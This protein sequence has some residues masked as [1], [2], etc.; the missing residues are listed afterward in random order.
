MS[1]ILSELDPASALVGN[2][3]VPIVQGNE[4]VRTTTQAIANLGGGGANVTANITSSTPT[5]LAAG[6]MVS[7]GSVVDTATGLTVT[8]E[9]NLT[10]TGNVTAGGFKVNMTGLV[11]GNG[12]TLASD[13]SIT[14]NGAGC[15]TVEDLVATGV[16]AS[17]N[18]VSAGAAILDSGDG[19]VVS[20]NQIIGNLTI[21][22]NG[23]TS[24]TLAAA[25]H[26]SRALETT[27]GSNVTLSLPNSL[28]VG[29]NC[30]VTQAGA[31]QITFSNATGAI[32]RNR[33]G[34]A[35]TAAQ[36][37]VASLYVRSNGNGSQAEYVLAGDTA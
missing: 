26:N 33:Q 36:W 28:P 19:G 16:I 10:A 15:L 3:I 27:S 2:E 17:D 9:G 32:L 18:S 37:A 20:G 14:T 8:G 21:V 11:Y 35:K 23:T 30:I 31:G 12:T 13:S 25:A 22:A 29:F 7:T 34:H 5:T 4:T 24:I 1:A 6:L